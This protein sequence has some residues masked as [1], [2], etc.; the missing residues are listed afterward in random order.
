MSKQKDFT[1]I[2]DKAR[3]AVYERDN[4]KCIICGCNMVEVAHYIP[5]SR[6]GMGIPENLVCLCKYHHM[7]FDNGYLHEEIKAFI[8]D[9]F[10]SY[11]PEWDKDKLIYSKWS[12]FVIR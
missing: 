7:E 3:Q 12:M 10:T 5:R 11:Y 2:T 1:R 9:Y 6:G 8:E 4:H